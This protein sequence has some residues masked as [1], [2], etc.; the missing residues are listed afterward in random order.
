MH[1]LGLVVVAAL[2]RAGM[3]VSYKWG[4]SAG[5]EPFLILVLNGILWVC[6]GLAYHA[7]V[8]RSWVMVSRDILRFGLISGIF[9]S[10]IV[11]FL[12]LALKNGEAGVVLPIT[13]LSFVLTT[14]LGVRFLSEALSSRKTVGLFLALVCISLMAV[15]A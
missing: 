3:G 9:V 11:L 8:E 10:G 2:L 13:Q 5:C 6:G 12:M 14:L 15:Q 7:V 1:P 4:L